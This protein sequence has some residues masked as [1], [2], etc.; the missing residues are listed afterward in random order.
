[1]ALE[2]IFTVKDLIRR[3]EK[4]EAGHQLEEAIKLYKQVVKEDTVK[5]Q[6]TIVFLFIVS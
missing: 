2:A 1:M 4:A 6:Q 3:A 5:Y